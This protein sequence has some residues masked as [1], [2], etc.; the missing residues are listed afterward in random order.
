MVVAQKCIG[1]RYVVVV[2]VVAAVGGGG[3]DGDGEKTFCRK[4]ICTVSVLQQ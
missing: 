4:T 2:T 1:N 3:G